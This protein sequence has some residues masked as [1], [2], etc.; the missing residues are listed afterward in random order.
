MGRIVSVGVQQP[1]TTTFVGATRP[2]NASAGLMFFNTTH[3]V[4][5]IYNGTGWHRINDY[6]PQ[7]VNTSSVVVSNR[8]YWVDTAGGAVTLTL[9][10]SPS[11]Y[12][13]IKFTDVSGS[14]ESNNLTINP[15][16]QRIMRTADNMTVSTNGASITMIYY[17]ATTG[18]LLEAI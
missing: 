18:W 12:D 4:L 11:Q 14:F 15:N 9:P 7:V 1:R 6:L 17:N 2:D 16:G 13:Y 3:S 8:T 10:S 5:E